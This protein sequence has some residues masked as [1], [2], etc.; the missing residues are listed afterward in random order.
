MR[1]KLFTL[2]AFCLFLLGWATDAGAKTLHEQFRGRDLVI[3]RPHKVKSIPAPVVFVLHG[4]GGSAEKMYKQLD[5]TKWAKRDGVVVVYPSA[6][7]HHWN[8]GRKGGV[9]LFKGPVP[10]DVAYLRALLKDLKRRGIAQTGPAWLMG[11]SNGGMM[12]QTLMCKA[13]DIFRAAVSMI[14]NLPEAHKDCKPVPARSILLINSDRD[15]L[16]PWAGGQVGF[17]KNRGLV[18]STM[19]SFDFWR[20]ANGCDG[21]VK[22][23]N[24]ANTYLADKTRPVRYNAT[25]CEAGHRVELIRV[26]G[27]GHSVPMPTG[28]RYKPGTRRYKKRE[29][30]LGHFNHDFDSRDMAWAF[31]KSNGL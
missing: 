15:P 7:E 5:L 31:F 2:A 8:D 9:D 19:Q 17:R 28:L 30:M 14:G 22:I 24:L 16:V 29:R 11:V 3:V 26:K 23:S 21:P 13:P 20:K 18:L 1:N 10:D 25:R 6:R 4:G 12:T 27:A